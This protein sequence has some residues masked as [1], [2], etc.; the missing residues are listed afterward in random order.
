VTSAL[1][2]TARETLEATLLLGLVL[3]V[4]RRGGGR[5]FGTAVWAGAALAL[6]ASVV[7]AAVLLLAL[8]GLG[9]TAQEAS[10][11]ALMWAAAALLTY[12]L[13]WLRR[14][15]RELGGAIASGAERALARRSRLALAGIVFLA[16]FREGA[17]TALYLTAAVGD[18]GA[19][20]V[21]TG[22]GLGFGA[23]AAAGW[24]AYAGGMRA[25]DPRRFFAVTE[26]VLLAFAAGLV[27]RATLELQAVGVFPGTITVWDTSG[28]LPDTGLVGG[29]L[30]GLVGYTAAPTLL[31]LVLWLGY[32]ALVA[33]L[34]SGGNGHAVADGAWRAAPIGS[35]Y[36]DRLYRFLRLPRLT[37]VAR[38]AMGVLL[39][40]L[41]A[42][43]LLRLD[44]GPFDNEGPLRVGPF[45][46]GG[47]NENN[48]FNFALWV[49]WLPLLTAAT[50]LLGRVWCGNLCPLR[51]ATDAAR[52][53]ADRL[54]FRGA[55]A[56]R[57]L[58][59]GWLLPSAFVLVTFLV[60]WLD[61]Q[62]VAAAGA[63][64]FLSMSALAVAV[65]FL[66]RTGTWCRYL[67]PVG[68]WLA[69]VARLSP[70]ALRA[71]PNVCA[72]CIDKPC[73][74]GTARAG[75]CPVA[76]NPPRLASTQHCLA[77]WS[78]VVNCPAERSSLRLVWRAPGAELLRPHAPNT[79]ESLF[80]A[81]ML[82]M[83]M[84]VGHRSPGLV[85]VPW[86]LLFFGFVVLSTLV[87]VAACAVSAPL[88][89]IP[90][91][92]AL[93][94]FG[95]I[96]LPLE[97]GT[98][99]I[100][101]GDDALELFG[102]VQPAASVLLAAGFVWSVVVGVSILRTQSRGGIRAVL[103]GVPLGAILLSLLFVWLQWYA[104]G[105]VLDPT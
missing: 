30:R 70:L 101:F 25:L 104:S 87:F 45:A 1:V 66:F 13:W 81:S 55:G 62:R 31:Q 17:E 86:P 44:V 48:L 102:A 16:V 73:L 103:A 39:A 42:V 36:G 91:R 47:E 96:F 40:L 37:L 59:L 33:A 28:L 3:A 65:G 56:S 98:A 90:L 88:A 49:L 82:G 63:V 105:P 43:A 84:A 92:R 95:Y 69:R 72:T 21:A 89:G 67:C 38:A 18:A 11:S 9:G 46:G 60:K 94:T 85:Q 64:F 34:W 54:G 10:E 78:C 4:L 57:R 24:L 58:R 5:G 79:W 27:A 99:L 93:S 100:A 15:A 6:A 23:A 7:L 76:L 12:V 80:V 75:R 53:L 68:G 14:H 97:F 32:L 19:G 71:D 29:V 50:L 77:C 22:A 41:L 83:Y 2:V 51:L 35:G 20:P 26:I 52:A 74:T 8:G 61:V